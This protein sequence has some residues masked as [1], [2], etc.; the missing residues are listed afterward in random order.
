MF[1]LGGNSAITYLYSEGPAVP[2][3]CQLL[4]LSADVRELGRT[5]PAAHACVGDIRASLRV[6]LPALERKLAPHRAAILALRQAAARG[7]AAQRVTRHQAAAAERDAPVTTPLVAAAEIVRAVGPRIAIV[8]EAPV[9]MRLVRG[10]LDSPSARQYF[11]MRSA[12][13]GWGMP[14]AVGVSLGLGREPVVSLVGDG[15]SL[16]SPQAL[17]T[18]A[19]ERLPVT[20]IVI[21]NRE[22]NILKNYMRSQAHYRSARNDRFIGM[23]LTDPAIDFVALAA[24]MGVPARRIERAG[25]IAGAVEAGIASGLPNLLEVRVSPA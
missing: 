3:S 19:R 10:F 8:D 14:A 17:W 15:S 20:F 6:L 22:Y 24:A 18:A 9:T 5:Y 12:I 16:Y 2:P 25:E 1:A 4:Q 13:L 23:D 21:N 7:R 11:F